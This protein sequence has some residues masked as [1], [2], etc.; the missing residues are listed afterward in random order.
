MKKLLSAFLLLTLAFVCKAG[1]TTNVTIT[2]GAVSKYATINV[3]DALNG[4]AV[5]ATISNVSVQNNNP[6]IATVGLNTNAANSIKITAV[7]AGS[8]TATVTC[9]VVYTDSGDGLQKSEDKTIVIAYTV[10]GS[11]HGVKLSLP[12]N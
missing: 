11:P 2:V 12:F 7:T 10:T 1:D 4:T 3:V 6:S 5:A 8:G 9:H